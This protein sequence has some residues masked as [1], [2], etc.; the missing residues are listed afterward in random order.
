[1]SKLKNCVALAEIISG[2]AVIVTLILLVLG[3]HGNT[4]A[5]YRQQALDQSSALDTPFFLNEGLARI[6]VKI[7]KV[8]GMPPVYQ[9][10][11]DAYGLTP[12][13]TILWTRHLE[14][15]WRAIEANYLALGPSEM[16]DATVVDL[17]SYPDD[18]LFWEHQGRYFT[19]EFQAYVESLLE[20]GS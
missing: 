16:G 15:L 5:L 18:A 8:D 11:E 3:V 12:E 2:L 1:V 14:M 13:E 10:F 6:L 17:L 7:K 9:A 20:A 4:R 19:A